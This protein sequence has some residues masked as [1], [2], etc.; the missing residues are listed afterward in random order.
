MYLIFLVDRDL[1]K[2]VGSRTTCVDRNS[3]G[4]KVTNLNFSIVQMDG[5]HLRRAIGGARL[6]L[7]F[8]SNRCPVGGLEDL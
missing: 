7:G 4:G 3:M 1:Y 5:L 8:L 2:S 6:F